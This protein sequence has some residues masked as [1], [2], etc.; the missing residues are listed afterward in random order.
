MLSQD[1]GLISLLHYL[2][3]VGHS[4]KQKQ[5]INIVILDLINSYKGWRH[6]RG[7]PVKNQRTW[8]N[9][10]TSYR[11]NLILRTFKLST[12]KQV[13][14]TLSNANLNTIYMAEHVNLIWKLQ[15]EN[16]WNEAKRK[17]LVYLNKAKTALKVDLNLMS[18]FLVNQGL[19][20]NNKQKKKKI[21]D[22]KKTF[23]P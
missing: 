6:L 10:W 4:L 11:N 8:S 5:I 19:K 15:W 12:L 16:E 20:K 18:N 22:K 13:Y 2:N 23:L 17:R 14:S 21:N 7:L 9:G 1:F 3:P